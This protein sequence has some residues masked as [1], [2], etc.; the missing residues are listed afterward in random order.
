MGERSS[1][2]G[3]NLGT[4]R[5]GRKEERTPIERKGK[6]KGKEKSL[7]HKWRSTIK[8][9]GEMKIKRKKEQG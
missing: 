7:Y 2:R 8:K 6:V 4:T 3:K 9:E 5:K 1:A